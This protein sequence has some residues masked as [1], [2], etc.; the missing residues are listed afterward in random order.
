[1]EVEGSGASRQEGSSAYALK[2]NLW[3]G[4]DRL[5]VHFLNPDVLKDEGWKCGK[6]LLNVTNILDWA[7]YWNPSTSPGI[8]NFRQT[9]KQEE[10][11]I[12]VKFEGKS[13]GNKPTL[14]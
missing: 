1:M 6:S 10:A 9:D 2:T 12:R 13:N 3:V 5:K 8:P 14:V 4:R 11:D 7:N